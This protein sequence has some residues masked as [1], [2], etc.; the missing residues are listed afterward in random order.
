MGEE[1]RT[2]QTSKIRVL[3]ATGEEVL[4]SDVSCRVVLS[5]ACTNWRNFLMEEHRFISRKLD[6]SIY[7]QHVIA[8]NVGLPIICHVK[9]EGGI[10]RVCKPTGTIFLAPSHA[11]FFRYC[12][13]A[14]D[15]VFA[16]VLYVAL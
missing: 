15:S 9:K 13:V 7:I 2:T 4:P 3:R 6:D 8:V 14:E 11:P 1:N 12:H 5:S 16:D 10:Q